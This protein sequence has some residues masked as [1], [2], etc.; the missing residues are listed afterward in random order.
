MWSPWKTDANNTENPKDWKEGKQ[1]APELGGIREDH[2]GRYKFAQAFI[3][4]DDVVLDCACGVGYGSYILATGTG[5]SSI[6]AVDIEEQAIAY[7]KKHYSHEKIEH[8]AADIFCL[9]LPDEHYDVICS[10]ETIEHLD[11]DALAAYFY[12]KLKKGDF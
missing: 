1:V 4:E 12:K 6:D 7:A 3:G 2:I 11:G 5:L 10:F 8:K 9:E